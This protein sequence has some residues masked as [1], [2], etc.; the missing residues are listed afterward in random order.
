MA[1]A[2][3][4][5]GASVD[6]TTT[7]TTTTKTPHARADTA[8]IKPK[9]MGLKAMKTV[10]RFAQTRG[11]VPK[12]AVSSCVWRVERARRSRCQIATVVSAPRCARLT[13]RWLAALSLAWTRASAPS[14]MK[15]SRWS[16]CKRVGT[17]FAWSAG[18]GLVRIE[19]T[20]W[21]TRGALIA[22]SQTRWI[23]RIR[24]RGSMKCATR[25]TST[26]RPEAAVEEGRAASS[27]ILILK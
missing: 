24:L 15:Q 5:A 6:T 1:L 17:G 14:A 18:S 27:H 12:V 22:D 4:S 3:S 10:V 9:R 26:G 20:G 25:K 11:A 7:T 2:S 23:M 21:A 13:R 16:D 8:N 19:P